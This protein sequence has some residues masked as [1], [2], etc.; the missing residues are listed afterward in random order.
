[1]NIIICKYFHEYHFYENHFMNII[2][3]PFS[4]NVRIP[5]YVNP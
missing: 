1:M 2:R 4:L 3:I 5:F